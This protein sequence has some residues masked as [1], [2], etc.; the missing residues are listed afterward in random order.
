MSSIRIFKLFGIETR[1]HAISIGLIISYAVVFISSENI[2]K[3]FM[4]VGGIAIYIM[5][6]EYGHAL[7]AQWLGIKT[8][9]IILTPIG[10]VAL[11][12]KE[13]KDISPK[14]ELPITVAGP[15]ISAILMI[16]GYAVHSFYPSIYSSH[17]I[18]YNCAIFIFNLIPAFP[19]D[20]GR[21]L[22]SALAIA[23]KNKLKATI[24]ACAVSK[25]F[26]FILG[27]LAIIS[28]NWF[29]LLIVFI[30]L[31]SANAELQTQQK[32]EEK[33]TEQLTA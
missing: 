15:M 21:I 22:R 4:F 16:L 30:L 23:L 32:I 14:K 18:R 25:F 6:H 26:L 28:L 20:G 8:E 1:I 13:I 2:A 27:I 19:M 31:V 11:F 33:K 10:G 7:M 3:Y 9:K 12:D 29:L 5:A 17:V 24:I